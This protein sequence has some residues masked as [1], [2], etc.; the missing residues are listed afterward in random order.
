MYDSCSISTIAYVNAIPK[1]V[2]F[3]LFSLF[4]PLAN[5][6]NFDFAYS[7][8]SIFTFVVL[9]S[10]C[11]SFTNAVNQFQVS[12]LFAFSSV[13]HASFALLPILTFYNYDQSFFLFFYIVI[14][15]FSNLGFFS[16]L[17]LIFKSSNF[18]RK[19]DVFSF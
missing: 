11:F 1:I 3:Y 2:Y 19:I 7:I 6:F 18:I 12:R 9:C 13:G 10:M 15:S 17:N 5:I 14:Y 8:S 4:L 16:L